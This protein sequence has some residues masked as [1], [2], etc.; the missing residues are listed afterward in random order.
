MKMTEEQVINFLSL[1]SEEAPTQVEKTAEKAFAEKLKQRA[2]PD[3]GVKT[4]YRSPRGVSNVRLRFKESEYDAGQMGDTEATKKILAKIAGDL[5][6]SGDLPSDFAFSHVAPPSQE[7]IGAVSGQFPTYIFTYKE[8]GEEKEFKIVNSTKAGKVTGFKEFTP[9]KVLSDS[10]LSQEYV[11]VQKVYDDIDKFIKEREGS[12][13]IEYIK[14]LT[15]LSKDHAPSDIDLDEITNE[16]V[17]V[18]GTVDNID[19]LSNA[20]KSTI[21]TDFGE[22][23]TGLVMGESGYLI[24]FPVE[25]NIQIIDLRVKKKNDKTD[26]GIGVSVKKEGGARASFT[27]VIKRIKDLESQNPG[28]LDKFKGAE[29][30]EI[31]GDKDQSVT[32][33]ILTATSY[34]AEQ[35]GGD[36]EKKWNKFTD[37][38]EEHADK[39]KVEDID[40]D[41]LSKSD[42]KKV[43]GAMFNALENLEEDNDKDEMLDIVNKFRSDLGIDKKLREYKKLPGRWGY[44]HYALRV[45]LKD[46]LNKDKE[47]LDSIR[48]FLKKLAVKQCHLYR[49]SDGIDIDI[50]TYGETKFNFDPGGS[51]SLMPKNQKMGFKVYPK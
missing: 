38:V 44:L 29:L 28:L 3:F 43:E 4:H 33:H 5:K 16:R 51:S 9:N 15:K 6:M 23:F 7:T 35:F 20:D 36:F 40:W 31:M 8:A 13:K 39:E 25:S 32:T 21:L 22:V 49:R 26:I 2:T 18:V 17:S 12:L 41:N 34:I 10:T 47:L 42:D 19:G 30:F 24:G 46:E 45:A 37:F 50:A 14:Y 1:I 48:S 27:G 11:D